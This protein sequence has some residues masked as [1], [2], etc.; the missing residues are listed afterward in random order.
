MFLDLDSGVSIKEKVLGN[1]K[2]RRNLLWMDCILQAKGEL[3]SGLLVLSLFIF[4][5]K[6][7]LMLVR[8]YV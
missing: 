5:C 2:F 6:V 8:L 7:V 4:N 3:C 1:V